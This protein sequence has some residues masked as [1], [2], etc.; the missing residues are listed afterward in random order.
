MKRWPTNKLGEIVTIHMGQSPPGETY[1]AEGVGLPFF[2]GKAEFGED[3]PVKVKWCSRP[4]RIADAGDIL[5][6]VRAPVG[7]TNF[8]TERCC[9]G[10]GLAALRSD[11][12][13]CHQRYV[14]YYLKRF[15]ADIA[16]RGV[17]ST[18]TAINRNDL[19]RL[20]LPVPPLPEQ[21]RIVRIL[22]DADELRKLRAQADRRTAGLI[23]A[24]FHDMFGDPIT[25]SKRLPMVSLEQIASV[26]RGKFTPRP[27]NDPSYYGGEHPFIQTGDIAQSDGLLTCWKQTLN[28]RGTKVSKQFPA[29]TVVIAIVGA[30]IGE[31]AILGVPVFCTDSV[32][33]IQ[34]NSHKTIPEYIW[35]VLRHWRPL[36]LSQAPATARANINLAIL[37]PLKI[38][39][40]ELRLQK[41]FA[42]R[43]AEMRAMETQQAASRRRLD[44]LF[45]S[46]L[47][48]AFQGEL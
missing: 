7:P 5:L 47:Q 6:S 28:K 23:P 35:S 33:G 1:N 15:E 25:N 43:I 10:R 36:F 27:R 22:D 32:V 21:E 34:A 46:L 18:F 11:P 45:A 41:E 26:E 9:I 16:A 17:G 13:K 3:H 29:G 19:E 24:L 39:L 30:T 38:P 2:Q 14:R 12:R 31:T 20:E 8:A 4:S 42:T 48:R 40:P 44:D 37:K